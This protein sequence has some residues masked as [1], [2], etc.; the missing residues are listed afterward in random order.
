MVFILTWFPVLIMD[1][2]IWQM[3]FHSSHEVEKSVNHCYFL[4]GGGKG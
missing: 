3:L 1:D 4:G 2:D